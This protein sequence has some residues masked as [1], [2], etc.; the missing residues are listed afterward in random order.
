MDKN[1]IRHIGELARLEFGDEELEQFAAQFGRIIEFVEKVAELDVEDLEPMISP[2][3][4]AAVQLRPDTPGE[5]LS[6]EDA[7]ENAPDN[8]EGLF[9]VP[10]II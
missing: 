2:L 10:R 4:E 7:L 8:K 6:P 1:Q 5:T 9:G 3:D